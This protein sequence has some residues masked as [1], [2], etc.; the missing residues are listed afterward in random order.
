[1][2]YSLVLCSTQSMENVFILLSQ[3]FK[4]ITQYKRLNH[5]AQVNMMT[6]LLKLLMEANGSYYSW[7]PILSHFLV[8]VKLNT[9]LNQCP[10]TSRESTDPGCDV[11]THIKYAYLK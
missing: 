11:Y 7:S 3:N 5:S 10:S 1:M 2:A 8:Q 6:N 4:G 9:L